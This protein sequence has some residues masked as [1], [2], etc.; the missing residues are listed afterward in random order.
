MPSLPRPVVAWLIQKNK[1]RRIASTLTISGTPVTTATLNVAY[2]GFTVSASGGQGAAYTYSVASGALP[3]GI[4]IDADTGEVS[5]TP[6]ETGAF[7]DIVIR[8]T[9]EAGNHV[10]LPPFTLTVSA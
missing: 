7:A 1:R 9:D 2:D 8:A 4:S 6:T 3:A 5:G 10:D